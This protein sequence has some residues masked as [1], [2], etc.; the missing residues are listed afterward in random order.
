MWGVPGNARLM[1]WPRVVLLEMSD[2]EAM[3][4]RYAPDGEFAGD[5]W[6]E[7]RA[8]A[9]S[10]L[11]DEYEGLLAEWIPVPVGEDSHEYAIAFAR[12]T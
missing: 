1:P 4:Y 9:L 3:V 10:A 5:T 7:T 6:H 8:D 12:S 11:E 2:E